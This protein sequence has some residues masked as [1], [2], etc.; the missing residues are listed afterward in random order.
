MPQSSLRFSIRTILVATGYTAIAVA[1]LVHP[2][3]V[4][5]ALAYGITISLLFYSILGVIYRTDRARAYGTGFALFGFG[6][7]AL[8]DG[9]LSELAAKL[10][11]TLVLDYACDKFHGQ[12]YPVPT[13]GPYY[14]PPVTYIPGP[15]ISAPPDTTSNSADT[16]ALGETTP[17]PAD[18]APAPAENSAAE[19][20]VESTSA[21]NLPVPTV[22]PYN[23][24]LFTSAPSYGASVPGYTVPV[25]TYPYDDYRNFKDTGQAVFALLGAV[26][27]GLIAQYL[28]AIRP[29]AQRR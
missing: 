11:T 24:P 22:A 18:A 13:S 17:E 7:L 26:I 21:Q 9:P 14:P 12:V 27:G 19:S 29:A 16:A 28:F 3:K 25:M 2:H 1:A 23:P 10:P 5:L 15:I 20:E 4:W 8:H 6:Y